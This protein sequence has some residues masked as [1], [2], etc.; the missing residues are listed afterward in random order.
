MKTIVVSIIDSSDEIVVA[1]YYVMEDG[2]VTFKT[3]DHKVV[4]AY[5]AQRVTRIKTS[6]DEIPAAHQRRSLLTP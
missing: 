1:E 4:A 5:P 2:W 6:Q 3:S